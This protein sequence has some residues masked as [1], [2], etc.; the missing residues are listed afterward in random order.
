MNVIL[1]L[2]MLVTSYFVKLLFFWEYM[3]SIQ[4]H[5]NYTDCLAFLSFFQCQKLSFKLEEIQEQVL[6]YALF[7]VTVNQHVRN[8][9]KEWNYQHS[10]P[11]D[12]KPLQ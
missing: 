10:I 1:W 2:A 5:L 11:D 7:I 3:T 12:H 9:Y 8:S 6:L 4:Y